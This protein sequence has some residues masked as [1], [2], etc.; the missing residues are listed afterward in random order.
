MFERVTCW[1][2][3][4]DC[5]YGRAIPKIILFLHIAPISIEMENHLLFSTAASHTPL[6]VLVRK[7]R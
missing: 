2:K 3:I 7:T 5:N 4:L 1:V 6:K